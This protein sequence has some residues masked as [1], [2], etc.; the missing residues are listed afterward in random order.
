MTERLYNKDAYLR[1]VTATVTGKEGEFLTF[2]RTVFAPDS[3]GQNSDLGTV[4]GLKVLLVTERNGEIMHQLSQA[5]AA[6]VNVGD[7]LQMEIDWERRFDHM[8]NHIG[9]HILSGLFKSEYDLDNKGF[10]LGEDVG[11][12]DIDSR[13]ITEEMLKRIEDLANDVVYRALP[14]QITMVGSAEEAKEYPLR[15]ELKADEDILIVTIPGV[16]CVACCCPHPSDTSQVGIIKITGTEKYKGMTRISFKCGKR[17][18]LDYRQKHDV[19]SMLAEKFSADEFTLPEKV[20][21]ADRKNDEMHKELNKMKGI[22]ADIEGE[23]LMAQEGPLIAGELANG[24]MDVVRRVSRK[25]TDNDQRP[26]IVSSAS[27]LCVL[28]TVSGS[29]GVDFGAVVKEHAQALGGKGGG[30]AASAQ[31]FF[32]DAESMRSFVKIATEETE[33]SL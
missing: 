14:V 7:Q 4:G 26:A 15:K 25:I 33:R 8:Q 17:A 23:R 18:L 3:G 21:A 32:G 24:D 29:C 16:D 11:T 10:R 22:V 6:G 2:D 9:E 30:K 12:F 28:M 1:S 13:E 19:I 27:D 5:D 20:A 31:A